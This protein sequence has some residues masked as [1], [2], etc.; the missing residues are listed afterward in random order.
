[1]EVFTG[2][3]NREFNSYTHNLG[4]PRYVHLPHFTNFFQIGI[5]FRNQALQFTFTNF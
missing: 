5:S 4:S 1:M 3:D 2:C